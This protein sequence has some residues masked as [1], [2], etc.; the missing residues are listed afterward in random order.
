M[1][2]TGALELLEKARKD[3]FRDPEILIFYN[4]ARIRSEQRKRNWLFRWLDKQSYR[5]AVVVPLQSSESSRTIDLSRTVLRGVA[6]KQ[7]QINNGG[8]INGRG[9]EVLIVDEPPNEAKKIA[10]ALVASDVIAVI[11]P[12]ESS[13]TLDGFDEYIKGELVFITPTSTTGDFSEKCREAIKNNRKYCFRTVPGDK[14][15][16]GALTKLLEDSKTSPSAIFY[17]VSDRYSK[18]I[19]D[20][21]CNE[22]GYESC[23]RVPTS[24]IADEYDFKQIPLDDK[25][26]PD[27]ES[28]ARILEQM[29]T[30]D[31]KTLLLFPSNDPDDIDKAISI[32][33][34]NKEHSFNFFIIGGDTLYDNNLLLNAGKALQKVVLSSPWHR[35]SSPN[36]KFLEET[37]DI[38]L[39]KVSWETAMSADATSAIIKALEDAKGN[40]RK[41]VSDALAE[42]E[43]RIPDDDSA[44]GEVKFNTEDGTRVQNTTLLVTV[45]E[46]TCS[47][48]G[49]AFT[50]YNKDSTATTDSEC[51]K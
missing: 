50:P 34:V 4:N 37:E 46:S 19:R 30:R 26:K 47:K 20:Q 14:E 38:W 8:R 3:N 28:V 45:V 49:Y 42:P 36:K 22:L 12:L 25:H 21:F 17:T 35:L 33:K 40:S 43:F 2:K 16:T 32:A 1:G 27:L 9:L 7:N 51:S 6:Q 11:G 41:D 5:V 18:S 24:Q 44:T 48:S 39:S 23:K 29:K 13:S 10:K 31:V 15:L